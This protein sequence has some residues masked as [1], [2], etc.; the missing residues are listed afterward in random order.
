[1]E[2]SHLNVSSVINILPENIFSLIRR[3]TVGEKPFKCYHCDESIAQRSG[4][5]SDQK[6]HN[7][8][9]PFKCDKCD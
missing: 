2:K 7:G 9:K 1:M 6:T 4:I 8:E 5:L 3:Y